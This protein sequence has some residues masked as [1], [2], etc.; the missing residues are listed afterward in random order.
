MTNDNKELETSN[1]HKNVPWME[2]IDGDLPASIAGSKKTGQLPPD[3]V[4]AAV[5]LGIQEWPNG[6]EHHFKARLLDLL[7]DILIKGGETLGKPV[8]PPPPAPPLDALRNHHGR[9]WSDPLDLNMPLW[10]ALV[11]GNTRHFGIE[12]KLIVQINAKWGVAESPSMTPRQLLTAFGF[13]PAEFSLYQANSAEP[14]PP[15]T[16]LNLKRGDRFEAQKDG[17]YGFVP[18]I[19]RGLQTL[20][21]D[22]EG[23]QKDGVNLRKLSHG[24]QTYVEVKG[25]EVPSPPWSGP[26][27]NI[28][29]AV[30][31]TYPNGGLDAFYLEQT[32]NQNGSVPYQGAVITVDSRNWGLISWH[33]ADGRAWHPTHDDLRSHIAHCRGF[34]LKRGIR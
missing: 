16:P 12:Y 15:D 28:L 8:L 5:N 23:L 4:H 34:F 31:A 21:Q 7:L 32:I 6:K 29:I 26:L 3:L 9:D 1:P 11:T 22:V 30:P 27:A 33:Y 13:D 18:G 20:D 25:N 17:K 19:P 10:L 14:L 2:D 24:N